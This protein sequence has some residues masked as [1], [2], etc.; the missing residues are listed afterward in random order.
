VEP[1]TAEQEQQR[2]FAAVER[3]LP[4]GFRPLGGWLFRKDATGITYDL[5]AA[6]LGQ[7]DRIEQQGMFMVVE[8]ESNPL[9]WRVQEAPDLYV[10]DADG[11]KLC[12]IRGY[13]NRVDYSKADRVLARRI[14]LAV[15]AHG[16]LVAELRRLEWIV[17]G[18]FE[19][20]PSCHYVRKAGHGPSCTLAAALAKVAPTEATDGR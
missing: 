1:E 18:G 6:D 2:R 12:L 3:L 15:N 11:E 16:V 9:P 14:T 5:S 13:A 10:V 4:M 8:E 19:Y 17:G 7:I 20:C